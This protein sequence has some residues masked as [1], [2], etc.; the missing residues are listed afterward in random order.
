MQA[1]ESS[2]LGPTT[3]FDRELSQSGIGCERGSADVAIT[4]I[5]GWRR[6]RVNEGLPKQGWKVQSD[7]HLFP[8]GPSGI[9]GFKPV[10]QRH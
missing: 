2:Q 5:Y 7:W 3:H 10:S 9:R 1:A 8:L 4:E 6:E